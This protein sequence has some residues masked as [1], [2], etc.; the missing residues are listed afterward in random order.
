MKKYKSTK[1]ETIHIFSPNP[2][3]IDKT[4]ERGTSPLNLWEKFKS[5][6]GWKKRNIQYFPNGVFFQ[7]NKQ[8]KVSHGVQPNKANTAPLGWFKVEDN[9]F[10]K[11]IIKAEQIIAESVTLDTADGK[12]TYDNTS[13]NG[14]VCY[15]LHPNTT[16]NLED[17]WFVP[18]NNFIKLYKE[19]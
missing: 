3:T 6:F 2:V 11:N 4:D 17:A 5:L 14:W 19:I 8:G 15:N 18:N 12:M 16:A 10:E 7:I 1:G 13:R 9:V